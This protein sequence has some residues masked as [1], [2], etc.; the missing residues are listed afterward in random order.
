MNNFENALLLI[1]HKMQNIQDLVK[2]D[3]LSGFKKFKDHWLDSQEVL[4]ALNISPRSLQGLRDNHQ[5]PFS[6]VRGKL[7]YRLSD[8]E[9]LMEDNLQYKRQKARSHG[10]R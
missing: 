3:Y 9:K 7:Y 8:L 2:D 6:R 1:L 5:L 10:N 4:R